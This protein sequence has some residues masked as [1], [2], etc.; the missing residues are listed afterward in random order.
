MISELIIQISSFL[1][2]LI[3]SWGYIGIL[4]LMMI[5][6]SFIPFPSEIVLIPA[7]SLVQQGD[8]SLFL[9]FFSALVGAL[10]GAFIN[11]F[12][13]LSLGRRIVNKLLFTY[14][15]F[16]LLSKDSVI[17]SEEYFNKHGEITTFVGRLLPGIRQLISLPAGFAKMNLSKFAIY[18]SLGAG[19]WSLILIALGY[20]IGE[21]SELI[22][23]YLDT[24]SLWII[25]ICAIIVLIYFIYN[26]KYRK[27]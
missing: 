27:N 10:L 22:K 16:F 18:T 19:I 3:L 12:L 21:N 23:N 11:Y 24:I 17:K 25:L 15:K 4:F 2:N 5:E 8:M 14:G 26:K 20:F 1:T 13:A 6:S 7:G 9:V